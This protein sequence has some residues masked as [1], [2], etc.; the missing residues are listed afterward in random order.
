MTAIAVVSLWQNHAFAEARKDP[1]WR[2]PV[3][4]MVFSSA[5][6]ATWPIEYV[7]N[8]VR[9]VSRLN[10]LTPH[11]K[12]VLQRYLLEESRALRWGRLG[13]TVDAL[14]KAKSWS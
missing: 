4:T 1:F 6:L 14:A 11:E 2:W 10:T 9:V 12:K 13:G 7:W 8:W 3:L 5:A